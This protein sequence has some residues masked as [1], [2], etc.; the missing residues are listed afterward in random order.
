MSDLAYRDG[1]LKEAAD[2]ENRRPLIR[3]LLDWQLFN[4]LFRLISSSSALDRIAATMFALG[5]LLVAAYATV[6]PDYNWDMVA[7]VG[8]ALEERY[9]DPVELHRETWKRIDAGAT[10]TQQYHLKFS[11]PYN[12]HQWENPAD[13]KSQL[14]MYRVKMLYVAALRAFEP[15]IGVVNAAFVLSIVPSLVFG[16]LVLWWLWREKALQG[17][18]FLMPLLLMADYLPLSTVVTPDML[19]TLIAMAA[20][21]ALYRGH[22]WLAA[23][24]LVVSVAV[25][26]DNYVMII[27]GAMTAV[28]FG[29]RKAPML[30]ALVA[31]LAVGV[32][33]SK[34]G[35]HPGWW[36]HFYFSNIQLQNSMTGFNPPFSLYDMARGYVRGLVVTFQHNDWLGLLMVLLG[37]WA[38]L[39]KAGKLN[40][41]RVHALA[42]MMAIGT[43]GKFASFPLPD[44]R[45]YF[46][47]I[48]GF[49]L[50][51][52]AAWK[53]QFQMNLLAK[54]D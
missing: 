37:G 5:I 16:A 4:P 31:G 44:D 53:P 32:L 47:F 14:S 3:R 17:A 18:F 29:W 33:I 28:L 21:Y 52:L 9:T 48:A 8:T 49:A 13:F 10:E 7:Y 22:D 12:V 51:L 36:T 1:P 20:I 25:R 38:L 43:L 34:S 19:L 23:V 15:V 50:V 27:A 45:F 39:A 42:F 24:L 41:P 26:P 6:R 2:G 54:R 30:T 35:H 11:N 46:V 40:H